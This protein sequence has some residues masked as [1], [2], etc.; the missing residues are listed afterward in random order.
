MCQDSR[1]R[2]SRRDQG[3]EGSLCSFT[4]MEEI[5]VTTELE[6]SV[7]SRFQGLREQMETGTE[8]TCEGS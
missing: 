1:A 5:I 4:F 3:K 6:I 8:M 2:I 7:K